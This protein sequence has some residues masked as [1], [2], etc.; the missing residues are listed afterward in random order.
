MM[1]RL[2]VKVSP[3]S[4]VCVCV[5]VCVYLYLLHSKDQKKYFTNRVRTFWESEDILVGPHFLRHLQITF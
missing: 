2:C 3:Q 4:S 5:C 1:E